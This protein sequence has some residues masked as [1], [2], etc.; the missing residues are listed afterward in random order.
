MGGRE[1]ATIDLIIEMP[2]CVPRGSLTVAKPSRAAGV[3]VEASSTVPVAE[4]R[5]GQRK[6]DGVDAR[7]EVEGEAHV[8]TGADNKA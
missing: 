4:E 5:D 2:R 6:D 7:R 3:T 1:R 8:G